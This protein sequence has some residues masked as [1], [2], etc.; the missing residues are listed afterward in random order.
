MFKQGICDTQLTTD[1][2]NEFFRHINGDDF[3]GDVTFVSTL[4]A[5]VAP[6][7]KEDESLSLKFWTSAFSSETLNNLTVREAVEYIC[8][9]KGLKGAGHEN[10]IDIFNFCHPCQTDARAWMELMKSTFTKVYHG[11]SRLEKITDFFNKT[12]Y[13]LC[14]INPEK[15][16]VVL[17]VERMNLRIMH[18]LQC[19]I[20]AFLPWYF[21]PIAGVS[22]IE[23]ELIRSLS[24][25]TS[26]KYE[27]CISKIAEQ[28]D[29]RAM[30]INRLLSGFETRFE[31]EEC[32]RVRGEIQNCIA[33]IN[34]TND[35]INRLLNIK[36]D[37]EIRLLGL[38]TK[39][40]NSSDESEIM[41]YFLRN[42]NLVLEDVINTSVTFIVKTYLEYFDEDLAKRV[43]DNEYSYIYRPNGRSCNNIIP[44]E[45]M[46]MLMS[47]IFLDR[48][49]RIKFCAAYRFEMNG[50]VRPL[51]NYNFGSKCRDC[52]PNT[53][54][55]RFGCLG[56]YQ[57][58]INE[59]LTHNNYIGAIEQC[60]ASCMSL[61]FNDSPVM[62]EFMRGI[63][64]ISEWRTN[65]RC[66]ELPDGTVVNPTEAIKW[67]KEQ[68]M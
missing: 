6:R 39:I 60:S 38:E 27:D 19:S 49:L 14:F 33:S 43:I 20:L 18:Y 65:N 29:F 64:G 9:G 37:C 47:A 23:I 63:Y 26:T 45:D 48:K 8:G 51:S 17:F 30:F 15:K 24:E 58:T 56:N 11:W 1:A 7:M 21:D 12:F 31:V 62:Q 32:D 40:A 4:R 28:Y 36:N 55:N 59:L 3:Q 10:Q 13:V 16:S 46:R 5:L 2:A 53:H 66:I 67:L 42:D 35:E 68:E 52:T 54:L 41:D 44:D 61:N 50:T 57:R 25:K 34:R 22:E